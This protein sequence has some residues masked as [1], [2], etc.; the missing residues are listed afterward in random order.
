MIRETRRGRSSSYPNI[1]RTQRIAKTG[2]ANRRLAIGPR[3]GAGA[4]PAKHHRPASSRAIS[5]LINGCARMEARV[6]ASALSTSRSKVRQ[7]SPFG[8]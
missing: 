7:C 6:A 3:E 4:L 8:L 5:R 2:P 1:P